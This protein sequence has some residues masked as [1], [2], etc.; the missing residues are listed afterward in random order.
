MRLTE[1]LNNLQNQYQELINRVSAK[2][3]NYQNL[4]AERDERIQKR[5]QLKQYVSDVLTGKQIEP[6]VFNTPEPVQTPVEQPVQQVAQQLVMQ[7]HVPPVMQEF[8]ESGQS[9][10]N[11]P[12]T[13][14]EYMLPEQ[15]HPTFDSFLTQGGSQEN[16]PLPE[17]VAGVSSW[18]LPNLT[19]P[20]EGDSTLQPKNS[21][22][23][24]PF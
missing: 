21:V 24:F 23:D 8:C 15:Q 4:Q 17:S 12:I 18:P 20:T 1:N 3:Y 22:M 19:P 2:G 6:P 9:L 5:D 7:E 14:E 16:S 10:P 11:I 13:G